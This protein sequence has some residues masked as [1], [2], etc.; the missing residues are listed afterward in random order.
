M[1]NNVLYGLLGFKCLVKVQTKYES[2][3]NGIHRRLVFFL[4]GRLLDRKYVIQ[5]KTKMFQK[6]YM[7]Y[8]SD[9]IQTE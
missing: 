7:L 8:N 4:A 9:N 1:L 2:N 6:Q 5:N 3:F